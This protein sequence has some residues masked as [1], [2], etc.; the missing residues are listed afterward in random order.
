MKKLIAI[1]IVICGIL[2]LS[3]CGKSNSSTES[4]SNTSISKSPLYVLSTSL[5]LRAKPS[6]SA[7]KIGL[8]G[9]GKSVL[10]FEKQN[11]NNKLSVSGIKGLWL[12]VKTAGKTG[13]VFSGFLSKYPAPN[14]RKKDLLSYAKR[15]FKKIGSITTKKA[16]K[17]M[18]YK[19]QRYNKGLTVKTLV[20]TLSGTEYKESSLHFS[21]MSLTTGFLIARAL[22]STD[23]IGDTAMKTSFNKSYKNGKATI[24][25]DNYGVVAAKTANGVKISFMEQAN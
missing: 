8:I 3:A 1:S 23:G 10:A 7:K 6:L 21:E 13:Y 16:G 9:Y 24:W 25:K 5:S 22:F 15:Y 11:I 12:K 17:N 20:T 18:V 4:D 14:L 2:I 19:N